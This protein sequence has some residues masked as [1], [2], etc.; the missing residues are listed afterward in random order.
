M[1]SDVQSEFKPKILGFLCNWCSYAGADLAGVSRIQYPPNIKIIRVMC[2]GRVDP[3]FVIEALSRGIDGVIITGCH[4]GDCHY[5]DGNHH[6]ERRF[7]A[8]AEALKYT[9]MEPER[10][11][12][13]WVS[14]SEGVRFGEVV[15][16]FTEQIKKLGPNKVKTGAKKNEELLAE[17]Q[18]VKCLFDMHSART[19]IGKEGELVEQG[20]VYDE[21]LDITEYEELITQSI[22]NEY[23][24]N[25]ILVSAKSKPRSVKELSN[26]LNIKPQKVLSQISVL[27]RKNMLALDELDGTTPMF[28]SITPEVD[29]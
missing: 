25:Y 20:N 26:N 14:A 19:L 10:I 11:R 17:L 7:K 16:D 12:L 9:K 15:S 2:S 13:E 6:T 5:Q 1:K 21:K 24:R 8:L 3:V 4:I 27:M 22:Q 18:A 28:I 23:I 29:V